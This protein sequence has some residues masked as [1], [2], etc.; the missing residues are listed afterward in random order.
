M[1]R[2]YIAARAALIALFALAIAACG[3]GPAPTPTPTPTPPP[4]A[5]VTPLPT[6]PPPPTPTLIASLPQVDP[7][8]RATV[9][10]FLA[11]TGGALDVYFEGALQAANL[12]PGQISNTV[13]PPAGSYALIARP[14]RQPDAAPVLN[15]PITLMAGETTIFVLRQTPDGLTALPYLENL[16]PTT[17]G[18]ARVTLINAVIGNLSGSAF[19]DDSPLGASTAG[20]QS[21]PPREVRPGAA[22][23]RLTVGGAAAFEER[24]GLQARQA[25]TLILWGEVGGQLQLAQVISPT[26][27]QT[28]IRLV[29]AYPR[30]RALD[31]SLGERRIAQA[32]AFGAA[33]PYAVY[34][35][36]AYT[37]RLTIPGAEVDPVLE[38]DI[39]LPEDAQGILAFYTFTGSDGQDRLRAGF[40]PE[41][42]SPIPAGKARLTLINLVT[43]RRSDI[44]PYNPTNPISG[45]DPIPYGQASPAVPLPA[46]RLNLAINTANVAR[47]NTLEQLEGLELRPNISYTFVI[48]G[49]PGIRILFETDLSA[50][51]AAVITPTPTDAVRVRLIHALIG[52]GAVDLIV[53]E[54]VV[55]ENVTYGSASAFIPIANT[56]RPAQ[57]VRA[58]TRDLIVQTAL[59]SLPRGSL[60]FLAI[61]TAAQPQLLQADE[62]QFPTS[63]TAVIR[64][65]HAAPESG[66][67]GIS[68]TST[69][70]GTRPNNPNAPTPTPSVRVNT[71]V[72]RLPFPDISRPVSL[73]VG[74]YTLEAKDSATGSVLGQLTFTAKAGSRY[75]VLIVPGDGGGMRLLLIG[76]GS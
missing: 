49:Q 74:E 62:R 60:T 44:Q 38:Q 53:G 8:Q 47:Q 6:Q 13:T 42:S 40:F 48:L 23:L 33:V 3:A 18:A 65:I 70:T 35:S 7:A 75:D 56:I 43:Q 59:R 37:L 41:D 28:R 9:R 14:A 31:V 12:R 46:G 20:G 4:A 22:T 19:L 15:T 69:F 26:Q 50:A 61:G 39:Q 17:N 76:G 72:S 27:R 24:V 21:T 57:L 64:F 5:T 58:G 34:P 2:F 52:V 32:L 63:N 16:R 25:Y 66:P 29:N 1:N 67:V 36:G 55:A 11:S 10:F 51:A 54:E 71:Y 68:S 30:E 73:R 45:F